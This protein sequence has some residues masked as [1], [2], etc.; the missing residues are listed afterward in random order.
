[1]KTTL[2]IFAAIVMPGGFIIL[3]IAAITF[4]VTRHR[5]HARAAAQAVPA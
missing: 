1:M 4:L 3:G 2:T 5:A